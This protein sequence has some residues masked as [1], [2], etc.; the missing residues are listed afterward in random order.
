MKKILF[1]SAAAI[2]TVV[3]LSSFKSTK[4][5]AV[6]KYY[7]QVNSG[8]DI[9]FNSAVAPSQVFFLQSGQSAPTNPCTGLSQKICVIGVT[10][11]QVT[12]INKTQLANSVT[13]KT[14]YARAQGQ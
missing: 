6:T 8:T 2:L 4:K 5:F 1:G 11:L 10:V 13:S 14:I 3:G 7:F 9:S 12:T